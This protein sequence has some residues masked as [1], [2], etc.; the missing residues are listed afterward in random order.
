MNGS[1]FRRPL[2]K[3]SK[4]K[5]AEPE[6]EYEFQLPEFDE[7]AFMR[8]E[9]ASARTSF[10]TLGVGVIAGILS[11]GVSHLGLTWTLGWVPIIAAMGA[12]RPLLQ[13]VGFDEE[14]TT[15]KALIGNYFMLFFTAL[16]IWILGVNLIN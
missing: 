16:A 7:R 15:H 3:K 11:L 8:R 13:S 14:V 6:E 10:W 1:P 2:A 9:V 4:D 12:L 5:K